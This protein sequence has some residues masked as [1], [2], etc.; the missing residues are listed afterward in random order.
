VADYL[1]SNVNRVRGFYAF[2]NNTRDYLFDNPYAKY[3]VN[4]LSGY[5]Q[6]EITLGRIKITPGI[7]FDYTGLPNKPALSAQAAAGYT[8]DYFNNVNVSPRVGFNWDVKG[9]RTLVVR[10]GSGVFVGRIPF[11]WLGYAYYNDGVGFGSFDVNNVAGKNK[12]DVL[13]DGAKTFAY[14]NGQANLV[15][16]DLISNGFKM[17]KVWRTNIAIDKTIQGYKFTVEGL[18]TQVLTD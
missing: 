6:D 4:L 11:A 3:K 14:N 17:P 18:Y 10:G 16:T 2:N 5:I 12:G 9:D 13:A 7:R 8:N 1:A 15:Q